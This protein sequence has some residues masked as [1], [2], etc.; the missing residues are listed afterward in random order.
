M[1]VINHVNC[2]KRKTPH[3]V[4]ELSRKAKRNINKKISQKLMLSISRSNQ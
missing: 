3:I 4:A 2:T 1:L